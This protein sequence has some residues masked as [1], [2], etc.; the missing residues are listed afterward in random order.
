MWVTLN[1]RLDNATRN[2]QSREMVKKINNV[3]RNLEDIID[4]HRSKHWNEY[5]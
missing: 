5:G 2:K 1:E 4:I 3:L